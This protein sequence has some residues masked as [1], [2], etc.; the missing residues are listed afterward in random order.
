MDS[1]STSLSRGGQ[2]LT[3]PV[4]EWTLVLLAAP[5]LA[6]PTVYPWGTIAVLGIVVVAISFV[7]LAEGQ[8]AELWKR[9]GPY[10]IPITVLT[11]GVSIGAFRSPSAALTLPKLMGLAL[12]ML[13]LRAVLLTG[14]TSSRIWLLAGAY[15]LIGSAGV[16]AGALVSPQW[17]NKFDWLYA[18]SSRIPR[19]IPGL[20]GAEQGVN[21]NALGGTTLLFLPLAVSLAVHGRRVASR[22]TV[23][24]VTLLAVLVLSQSR[25]AWVSAAV[26][27][28]LLF[29]LR[30]RATLI[31]M[32]V[33]A[34]ALA[35]W[36]SFGSAG[37]STMVGGHR[38]TLWALALE[39]IQ[40][41]PLGGVGLGAFR[42][43]VA[44]A[45]REVPQGERIGAPHAHNV[46]L[47]VALDTGFFGLVAYIALLI[48]A[49]HMTHRILG[50][51]GPASERA[52]CLGLW[53]SL[54][55]V[56]VFGLGDA[57]ALGAKV[58][59]FFWWNLGLIAALHNLSYRSDHL[60]SLTSAAHAT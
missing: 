15:L 48:V 57:I 50:R 14:T 10:R 49:T 31:C 53:S 46:F 3:S 41:H 59:I 16:L 40:T 24:A 36:L 58:G 28:T 7:S 34:V 21:P 19:V 20:P 11:V 44:D 25:T 29:A 39:S 54:V 18:I 56:H 55:A 45:M 22:Y 51:D 43:V 32:G 35:G 12:G 13:V 33:A 1:P 37:L 42:V 9:A 23:A 6:F 47:Q 27:G 26:V 38:T 2:H 4:L 60:E 52:L 5:V 8:A 17:M 30:R